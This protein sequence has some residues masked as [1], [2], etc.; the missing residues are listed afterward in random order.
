MQEEPHE[1]KEGE[2]VVGAIVV[3]EEDT[4]HEPHTHAR[5]R[6]VWGVGAVLLVGAGVGVWL[7]W[8]DAI[9]EACFGEEVCSVEIEGLPEGGVVFEAPEG[10][11]E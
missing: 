3:Q 6:I 1:K 9:K 8:G 10:F 7:Y 11:E 4:R 5:P 2:E